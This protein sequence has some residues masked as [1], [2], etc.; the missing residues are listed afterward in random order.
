MNSADVEY[1]MKLKKSIQKYIASMNELKTNR[2]CVKIIQNFDIH[3][4]PRQH[5][6]NTAKSCFAKNNNGSTCPSVTKK[7]SLY[8]HR[9]HKAFGI[10]VKQ[11]PSLI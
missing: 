3:Y 10:S 7:G 6:R 8:C 11:K 5:T 4:K 1:S 2:R 9:H